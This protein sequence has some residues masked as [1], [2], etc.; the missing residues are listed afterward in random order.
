M[1]LMPRTIPRRSPPALVNLP[2][3][4]GGALA[5]ER[6]ADSANFV[7]AGAS[8]ALGEGNESAGAS[9]ARPHTP[10]QTDARGPSP[11]NKSPRRNLSRRASLNW[12]L[13]GAEIHF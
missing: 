9:L 5:S 4:A 6:G 13:V 3:G 12:L 2:A 7:A 8:A 11:E 1:A 10:Q